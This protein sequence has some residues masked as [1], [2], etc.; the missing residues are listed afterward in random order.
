MTIRHAL[1]CGNLLKSSCF[2]LR[3]FIRHMGT[4]VPNVSPVTGKM[5]WVLQDEQY[6]YHQEIARYGKIRRVKC[7]HDVQQCNYSFFHVH[8]DPQLLISDDTCIKYNLAY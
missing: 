1:R 5:E 8:A 6:D 3:H 4:F 2:G 7:S